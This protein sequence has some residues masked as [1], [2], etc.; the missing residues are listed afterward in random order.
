MC[1]I[2]GSAIYGIIV[3]V[4]GGALYIIILTCVMI[5][6]FVIDALRKIL[7]DPSV[8]SVR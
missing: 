7:I 5:Y 6:I 8:S 2:N 4:D 1:N 3:Y